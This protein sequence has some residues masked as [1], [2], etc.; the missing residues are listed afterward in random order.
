MKSSDICEVL[1]K[2]RLVFIH[3]NYVIKNVQKIK[4]C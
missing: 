3:I 2:K 1:K 4:S